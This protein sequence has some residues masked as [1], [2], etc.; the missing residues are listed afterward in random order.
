MGIFQFYNV[1]KPR[2]FEHKPIYFDP[3]KEALE[4]RIHK[5]KVE[6]GVEEMDFEQYKEDIRGSFIEGT[7]HLKKSRDKGDDAHAR[8]Y[9][10]MRLILII[11]VLGVLYWYFY[12]R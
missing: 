4:K 2:Q 12:L 10:N 8:L 11:V 7:S 5:V 3:R 9:R 1:R 6:L